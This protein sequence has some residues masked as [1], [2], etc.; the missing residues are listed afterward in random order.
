MPDVREV[1][2]MI[3]KQKPPEPGA[4]QRQQKRQVRAARNRKYGAFAVAAAIGLV[5]VVA[6]LATR[7]SNPAPIP[8]DSQTA[9]SS[10]IASDPAALRV[11]TGFVEAYGAFDAEGAIG[12]LADGADV[13]AL[14]GANG[15]GIAPEEWPLGLSWWEATGYEQILR[16]CKVTGTSAAGTD[17]RCAL[18]YHNFGSERLGRGPFAGSYWDLTVLDGQIVQGSQY[19]EIKRFSPQM[20]EP[21]ARWVSKTYPKDAAVMYP[22]DSLSD[23]VLTPESI[24]LWGQHTKDYVKEVEAG[25]AR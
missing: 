1:Y 24:A 12:Y 21:F 8:A 15:V 18:D 9:S 2:E 5:A 25:T 23:F 3:T 13:S 19:C 6:L 17:V 11:A 10:L 16:S 14:G 22:D 4:L 7:G 20:W